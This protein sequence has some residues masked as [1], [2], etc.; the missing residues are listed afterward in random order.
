M[1]FGFILSQSKELIAVCRKETEHFN[2]FISMTN[3]KPEYLKDIEV[4]LDSVF[5]E[6][7]I[8]ERLELRKHSNLDI[9][10]YEGRFLEKDMFERLEYKGV[11][12]KFCNSGFDNLTL[13]LFRLLKS[14]KTNGEICSFFFAKNYD[15]LRA[16]QSNKT[17]S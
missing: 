3:I 4:K 11:N 5:I 13:F 14:I 10:D 15:E 12:Y 17:E 7:K 1:K 16:F 9:P 8:D 2:F 6:K